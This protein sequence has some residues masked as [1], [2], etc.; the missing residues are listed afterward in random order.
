MLFRTIFL[1][2]LLPPITSSVAVHAQS[3][4][5]AGSSFA[6]FEE[7]EWHEKGLEAVV[8]YPQQRNRS[9]VY[10]ESL[11]PNW[12]DGESHFWYRNQIPGGQFEFVWVD[13]E[14]GVRRPAFD[15]ELLKRALSELEVD[16]KRVRAL[17]LSGVRFELDDQLCFFEC[18]G[19]SFRFSLES[20]EL[21]EI[22]ES[23]NS[24]EDGKDSDGLPVYQFPR[25]SRQRGVDSEIRFHNR[26][27][28]IANVYW[29]DTTGKRVHYKALPPNESHAQHTFEYH[30]WEIVDE[31]DQRIAVFQATATKSDAF[32]REPDGSAID[33]RAVERNA[34]R[35]T[36]RRENR[37]TNS[38]ESPDGK[39]SYRVEDGNVF[40]VDRE[41]DESRQLTDD[42]GDG[43]YYDRLEWSG[44]SSRLIAFLTKP[45]DDF[46]VHLVESSPKDG[47]RAQLRS[48]RY[49]LPGDRFSTYQLAIFDP[50]KGSRITTSL[51]PIDFGRP[52]LRWSD[53]GRRLTYQKVDRG[54]QRFR[55]IEVD[56]ADGSH[57]NIIDEQ[58]ETFVWT[59][60]FGGNIPAKLTRLDQT[61]EAIY[62]SEQSGWRH[63][64]LVDLESDESSIKPI[65]S[66]EFVVRSIERVDE[67]SRQIW[68]TA[69]GY[70]PEQDPYLVHHFRVNFDGSGFT[71]LTESNGTHSIQ[72]S[73]EKKY[74]VS[75]HS[76]VDLPPVHELRN[77]EDGKQICKLDEA[78]ISELEQ[79][80]WQAPEVFKAKGRDGETDIWG[81]ICRP[82]DFDPN[83]SYP[84]IE[85][86]YAGPH[87]SFVP[88]RFSPRNYY[89]TLTNLGFIVVKIDGMGTA[90]RS[91]AFHDVC[92]HNL[93]D[94]G[95]PDRILWHQAVNAKYDYYDTDRV[96]IYGVSAGGQ[97]STGAMLFHPEFYKAA[98]SVC[99]C[100]DNRMDKASWNEQWMGYPVGPHYGE[101]SNIDNAHRLEGK[102][103]L[104]VGELDT[105]VPPES[106][107][108]L[109][110][111][112]IKADKDFE[113]IVVPGGGHGW[114]GGYSQRRM[115]EFFVEHLMEKK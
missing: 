51:D 23:A 14:R 22:D 40:I 83:K 26:L 88:K 99:G 1:V 37:P 102:L 36:G 32:I 115:R 91:K 80:G 41:S 94:A 103:M 29:I 100:H 55:L 97:N 77:A 17:T 105:N 89:D 85:D 38:S 47:G 53:D 19:R 52:R 15:H 98:V 59:A 10:K 92:W 96:G 107:M 39:W 60:H 110:D 48:R 8:P 45:G 74:I 109:V 16:D 78:D 101:S 69:S 5:A 76:R 13:V 62:S 54:H 95:L 87:N 33:N 70:Y 21:A 72:W 57:R 3:L 75:T 104:V 58:A 106:T 49:P 82:K 27:D 44:D 84:V 108:R 66:G 34:R 30:Y 43:S 93:K 112:L 71:P 42:A 24:Q 46:Q 28:R 67:E 73:P 79:R 65:T 7:S 6:T 81:I 64:Y 12:F 61:N 68:L 31:D 113:L 2:L 56:T 20:G 86:I 50:V 9:G 25:A 111:A 18:D 63:L 11:E 90:N 35:G 114:G 4:D